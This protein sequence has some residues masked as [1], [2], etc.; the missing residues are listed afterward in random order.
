[1]TMPRSGVVDRADGIS[2]LSPTY[3]AAF[4]GLLRAA[5]VIDRDLDRELRQ[6][7]GIGLPSFE[8]LLHLGAFSPEGTLGMGRLTAQAPLSQSRVSRIVGELA[9]RGLVDRGTST[10]DS[11]SVLVSLTEAGREL[12]TEASHTHLDGLGRV[13]F[14]RLTRVEVAELARL[15]R[16]VLGDRAPGVGLPRTPVADR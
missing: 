8:I 1:M 2:H 5:E 6:A 14:S 7:H 9:D 13:L 16:K 3:A 10:D 4:L 11:R 12:L 15:T